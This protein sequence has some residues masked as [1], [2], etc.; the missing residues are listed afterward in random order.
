MKKHSIGKEKKREEKRREEKRSEEKRR[1]VKRREENK[2]EKTQKIKEKTEKEKKRKE[3]KQKR[4]GKNIMVA[5][6][7]CFIYFWDWTRTCKLFASDPSPPPPPSPSPS[8][9][10]FLTTHRFLVDYCIYIKKEEI[11]YV[12]HSSVEDSF[13]SIE[14]FLLWFSKIPADGNPF[15]IFLT[16]HRSVQNLILPFSRMT[17]FIFP[18][19]VNDSHFMGSALR[20]GVAR[21]FQRGW[22]LKLGREGGYSL[23]FL[24]VEIHS[25]R[26]HI[27]D[28][29]VQEWKSTLKIVHESTLNRVI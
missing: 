23:N 6:S 2:T 17:H 28:H 15:C 13:H 29:F 22:G 9:R 21:I 18:Y 16:H 26:S 20:S 24:G 10:L 11:Y 14:S 12:G 1:E 7:V 5:I 19:R 3:N 8:P 25:F 4:K 27:R